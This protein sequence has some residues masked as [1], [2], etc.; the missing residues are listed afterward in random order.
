MRIKIGGVR[1][2]VYYDEQM[3][4]ENLAGE[5]RY[6]QDCIRILPNLG[7]QNTAVVLWHESI[8]GLFKTLGIRDHD[9]QLVAGLAEGFVQLILD[10]PA[11]I[12]Y[13][14]EAAEL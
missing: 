9:E 2:R 7:P 3:M 14:Q 4:E 8:H 10:N 12:G 6:M 1:Y 5:I 13:T 11:L